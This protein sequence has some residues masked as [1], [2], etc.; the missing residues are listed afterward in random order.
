MIKE[1]LSILEYF[2]EQMELHGATINGVL[3]TFNPEQV[4]EIN[5]KYDLDSSFEDTVK[6]LNKLTS[7]EYLTIYSL[8]NE[9]LHLKITHKGV[10]V[11]NSV[12]S[13]EKKL[14][15]RTI[16][17]KFSDYIVEHKGIFIFLGSILSLSLFYY[18]VI[19]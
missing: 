7:H 9:Y 1:E 17:K 5:K 2:V 15:E 14:K 13:K 6:V 11:V 10:G 18:K 16:L 3:L 12:R 8:G 19:K 4:E